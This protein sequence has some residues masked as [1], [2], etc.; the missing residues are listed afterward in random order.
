MSLREEFIVLLCSVLLSSYTRQNIRI[1]Q[2]FVIEQESLGYPIK[3]VT[4]LHDSMSLDK[5]ITL[6]K[7]EIQISKKC[8]Q[9]ETIIWKCKLP[10]PFLDV[11]CSNK[12]AYYSQQSPAQIHIP[13]EKTPPGGFISM[14]MTPKPDCKW[15]TNPMRKSQLTRNCSILTI[16]ISWVP[17]TL[18]N[19]DT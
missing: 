13:C 16:T 12:K 4:T 14:R 3:M 7:E 10:F 19:W 1:V 15:N 18:K 9:K 5:R 11:W 2:L 6:Q 17:E 8:S